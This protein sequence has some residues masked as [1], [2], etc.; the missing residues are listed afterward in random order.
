MFCIS[1]MVF[2][3]SRSSNT[4]FIQL[5]STTFNLN[6]A[7]LEKMHLDTFEFPT[8]HIIH[9]LSFDSTCITL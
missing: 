2:W 6:N 1:S 7:F 4:N 5:F 9:Y 3:A 8:P